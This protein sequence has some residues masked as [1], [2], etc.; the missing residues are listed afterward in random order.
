MSFTDHLDDYVEGVAAKYLSAVDANPV[1]SNQHEI[2]GLVKAGFSQYL[3]KPGRGEKTMFPS[4]LVY[5]S[6]A[7]EA[8][9]CCE[10]TLTWYGATRRDPTRDLEYRL[11]YKSNAVT[12]L[13]S[14]G[15]FLLVAKLQDGTLLLVFTP[16]GGTVEAQLVSLFNLGSIGSAFRIG[17]PDGKAL[18]LPLRLLLED[19]GLL[20]WSVGKDEPKWLDFLIGKFG[21]KE[22]PGT[23][24][25]SRFARESAAEA[26]PVNDP[27]GALVT[28]MDHEEHLFRVFERHLVATRLKDGFGPDGAD[29]DEF[30]G[31][32]LSVQN[33]RK[34]RVGHAFEGHLE[35]IFHANSL[36]F[37]RG[38]KKAHFTENNNKPDFL[39]PDFA[40]YHDATYPDNRLFILG[41]K[42]TC[43]DRWRQVIAEANRIK[44]KHLVTLEA[45]I[46]ETQTDQMEASAVQLIV[47]EPIAATYSSRQRQ[48]LMSLGEFIKLVRGHGL[49][50]TS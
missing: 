9:L 16:A 4:R 50:V 46:S 24:D 47:P 7:D 12:E 23:R 41:A 34:S 5:I 27:D 17:A 36:A 13:I 19:I 29:V 40:R 48:W 42:T 33:R 21:E 11:Y 20:R 26:D 39:F 14:E 10:D 6:D 1:K 3:G 8:P 45:A 37:E 25:F 32:S 44:R 18:L 15:D 22:F 31:Y 2:G 28:W 43:K 49:V 35:A 38:T 30:I